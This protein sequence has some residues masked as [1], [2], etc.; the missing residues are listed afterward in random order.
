MGRRCLAKK[1]DSGLAISYL[2]GNNSKLFSDGTTSA[3]LDGSM[4]Q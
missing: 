1:T 2:N 3:S 4:G